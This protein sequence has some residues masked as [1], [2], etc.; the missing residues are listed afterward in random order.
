MN[1]QIKIFL[2]SED[3]VFKAL[4]NKLLKLNLRS[5]LIFNY[6]SFLKVKSIEP[7]AKVDLIILDDIITG[8]ATHEVVNL[9]RLEK[10]ITCPIYYFSYAEYEEEKKA[11]YRGANFFFNKPFDPMKITQHIVN[12]VNEIINIQPNSKNETN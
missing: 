12:T 6:N 11:L 10:R 4:L 7:G 8:S 1:K 9:L 3:V 2:I 5:P